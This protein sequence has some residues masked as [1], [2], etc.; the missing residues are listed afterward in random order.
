MATARA[1]GHERKRVVGLVV[2]SPPAVITAGDSS[3]SLAQGGAGS[4]AKE[5]TPSA[6]PVSRVAPIIVLGFIRA[7]L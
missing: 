1:L 7:S 3:R 5:L 4:A 2:K 6:H